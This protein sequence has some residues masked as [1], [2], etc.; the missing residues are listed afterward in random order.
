MLVCSHLLRR[1]DNEPRFL[2]PGAS[3]EVTF[4][5][6]DIAGGHVVIP[7]YDKLLPDSRLGVGFS[8]YWVFPHNNPNW[9]VNSDFKP[10]LLVILYSLDNI[11][12]PG[13]FSNIRVC[14]RQTFEAQAL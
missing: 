2:Y 10:V 12:T 14:R 3:A 6:D 8:C 4:G 9:N 5:G 7:G 11:H 13:Q 1:A